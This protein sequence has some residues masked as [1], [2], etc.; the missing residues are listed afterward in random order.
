MKKKLLVTILAISVL[1]ANVTGCGSTSEDSNSGTIIVGSK[2]FTESIIL[3][4]I[5]AL[6]LEDAGIPVERK[7]QIGSQII[8]D[9]LVNAEIDMYPEYTGTGLVTHLK[10]DP[11]Y[12][13]DECYDTVKKEYKEQFQVT[14]L[15]HSS[16]NDSEGLAVSTDAAE[17]YSLSTIS[18]AWAHASDL[19]ISGTGEFYEAP[20]TY[21]RLK[22][23]YGDVVFKDE[24]T[25]DHNLSF[26]AATNGEV[27]LVSVYTTEGSLSS[28][29]F[30]I[31]EDDK[32]CWPPYYLAPV[33]RDEALEAAPEA[34]EILNKVTATFTDENV[35]RMNSAVDIDG[36]DAEDVAADYFETIKGSL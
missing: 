19:V 1:A 26:T 8:N 28:G 7:M 25:M 33:I 20:E 27:D 5:Y 31:L 12:D 11:I 16:V 30:V 29:D 2:D 21:P 32:N 9:S 10:M 35:I 6:A 34:E 22:E 14:W 17:K 18:D 24:V 13:P 23:L 3:A 15:E 36:E 4:E